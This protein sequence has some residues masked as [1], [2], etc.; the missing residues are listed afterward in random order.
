MNNQKKY[1]FFSFSDFTLNGGTR[2]RTVPLINSLSK[3]N[4]VFLISNCLNEEIFHKNVKHIYLNKKISKNYLRLFIFLNTFVNARLL[5]VLYYKYIK[6][7]LKVTSGFKKN[8]VLIFSGEY[9]D[10]I[11]DFF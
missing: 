8:D 11:L 5:K 1:I 7:F 10:N 4:D 3:K 6:I 9:F 2:A